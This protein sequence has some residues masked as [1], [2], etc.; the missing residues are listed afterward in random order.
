LD[1]RKYF[2]I[3]LQKKR[4]TAVLWTL[5]CGIRI[6]GEGVIFVLNSIL[7]F[8]WMKEVLEKTPLLFLYACYLSLYLIFFIQYVRKNE[9]DDGQARISPPTALRFQYQ[10]QYAPTLAPTSF[11]PQTSP[12]GGYGQ[13]MV[14]Y[15]YPTLP[16]SY[17][18]YYAHPMF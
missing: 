16:P 13:P 1:L 10:T 7:I 11:Q 14:A 15:Q 5:L 2:I 3:W 4:C 18:N 9:G 6:A 17:P 8:K 12:Y